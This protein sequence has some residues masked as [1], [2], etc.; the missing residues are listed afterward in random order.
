MFENVFG[1]SKNIFLE[2]H[3]VRG[4]VNDKFYDNKCTFCTYP[5]PG[6]YFMHTNDS[7]LGSIR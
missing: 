1:I 4:N 5:P 2:K 7:R 3:V 6:E